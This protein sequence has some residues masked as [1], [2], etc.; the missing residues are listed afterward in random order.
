ML[1]H[2]VI[3]AG[4]P[5]VAWE[6]VSQPAR[7]KE[8]APHL[9][10]AWRLGSPAVEAS[11]LGVAMLAGVIPIPAR[12]EQVER[13]ATRSHWTWKVGLLRL[14]HEVRPRPHGGCEIVFSCRA[15]WPIERALAVSYWPIVGLLVERLAVQAGR[16]TAA[17]R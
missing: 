3:S 7:W 6:L 10:G 4:D 2:S 15:P 9:R 12:I 16:D 1:Q 8:W 11:S 13:S 5:E 17:A 14:D